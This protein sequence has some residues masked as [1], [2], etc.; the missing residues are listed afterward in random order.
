MRSQAS[1]ST[2]FSQFTLSVV[3]TSSVLSLSRIMA[4][5]KYYH[6]PMSVTYALEAAE[7]PRLLNV[8]GHISLSTPPLGDAGE[9]RRQSSADEEYDA[10]RIDLSLV[11]DWGLRLCVGKEWYRFPGHFL[12][13]D[14]VRVDWIKSEFD[15]MLPGH[16]A[17]T[18]MEGELMERVKGTRVV[19]KELNDL[20]K[21]AASFYVSGGVGFVCMW[22]SGTDEWMVS[23]T[24][25]VAPS[26]CDYLLDLDF[27]EHPRSAAHEP[28]YVQDEA[29]WERV[30]CQPFLDAAHSSL[31][32][33]TLWMP[34]AL[35]QT[36]NS[37]GEFCLLRHRANV[38]EKERRHTVRAV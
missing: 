26:E 27:P 11:A 14:G 18:A 17:V 10:P 5:W 13:P 30:A 36:R 34:G 4:H 35:W 20:N 19:P 28:R 38:G 25:Q 32:T 24:L 23:C 16:F 2:L 6:S 33:R 9:G 21:E 7:V 3:V 8:T 1:R 37:Y 12:V 31:L 29:T 22:T 15:G